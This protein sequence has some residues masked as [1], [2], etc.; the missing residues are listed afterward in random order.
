VCDGDDV[1]DKKDPVVYYHD[2]EIWSSYATGSDVEFSFDPALPTLTAS[3]SDQESDTEIIKKEYSV[4]Q[5][6]ELALW[7]VRSDD[8]TYDRRNGV[9]ETCW[10][11]VLDIENEI[12]E[13]SYQNR[14]KGNDQCHLVELDDY[15]IDLDKYIQI[16][17]TQ[18]ERQRAVERRM[19]NVHSQHPRS[20]RFFSDVAPPEFRKKWMVTATGRQCL[21]NPKLCAMKACEGIL[22]EG[23]LKGRGKEA[24]CLAEKLRACQNQSFKQISKCC[25][26]LYT[27]ESFLFKEANRAMRENDLTKVDV[28]GPYCYLLRGYYR[29]CEPWCG[30]LYR[31]CNCTLEV[32]DEYRNAITSQE[33]KTWPS[34]NSTSKN[35]G[36]AEFF[37]GNTLFI[38]DIK[39]LQLAPTRAFDIQHLSYFPNEEEV[40][41]P[42]G[43]SFQV[44]SV[45][46]D[47]TSKKYIIYIQL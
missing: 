6:D 31:S 4:S 14:I 35:R 13:E 19:C 29:T 18:Q 27:R 36:K 42:P 46:Q 3:E 47:E 39:V 1:N 26:H 32:I 10:Q 8:I 23:R 38:I 28:L 12:I 11:P 41:L 9:D 43:V 40:L 22:T 16:D 24:E 33:W 37:D 30:R 17:K 45:Q 34:F 15:L 7:Y 21:L 44:S 25:V 20:D 2:E 5:P